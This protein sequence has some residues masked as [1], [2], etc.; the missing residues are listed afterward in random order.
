MGSSEPFAQIY[1]KMLKSVFY[2]KTLEKVGSVKWSFAQNK[3]RQNAIFT[4][5]WKTF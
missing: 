1:K 3:K 4:L 5:R 2:K